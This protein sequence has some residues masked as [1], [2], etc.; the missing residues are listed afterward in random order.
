MAVLSCMLW[1]LHEAETREKIVVVSNYTSTLDVVAALCDRYNYQYLRLD[2]ST[3]THRRQQ[4]VDRFNC[5]TSNDCKNW[6]VVVSTVLYN[7]S[8]L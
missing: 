8:Y 4:L 5:A 2:G 6:D 7:A 1:A 3:P